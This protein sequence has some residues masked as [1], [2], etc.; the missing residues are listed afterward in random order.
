MI[1]YII[2]TFSAVYNLGDIMWKIIIPQI[3]EERW[4]KIIKNNNLC[5]WLL[6]YNLLK[7]KK[8]EQLKKIDVFRSLRID[9]I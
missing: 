5:N 3:L 2:F 9:C 1:I 4:G 6:F 7:S 8:K